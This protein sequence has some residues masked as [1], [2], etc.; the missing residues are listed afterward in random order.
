MRSLEA[1][2]GNSGIENSIHDKNVYERKE[3][4][5]KK[6]VEIVLTPLEIHPSFFP[7]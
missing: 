2:I 1:V 3:G 7:K 6:T 5:K 4:R